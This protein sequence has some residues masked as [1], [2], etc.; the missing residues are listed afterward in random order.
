MM[1]RAPVSSS[2]IASIG[3]DAATS[4]LEIEF[5]DGSVYQY[6][7]VPEFIYDGLMAAA[8]H[9]TYLSANIKGHYQ[10]ARV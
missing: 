10:F 2:N 8:S 7:D 6:Y 9:G 4:V 3:F 1:D 5:L